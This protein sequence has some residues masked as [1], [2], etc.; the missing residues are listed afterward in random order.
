M[1]K[2][3]KS[4]NKKDSSNKKYICEKCKCGSND[5]KELCKPK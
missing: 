3:C 2:K 4:K 1:K 5:K